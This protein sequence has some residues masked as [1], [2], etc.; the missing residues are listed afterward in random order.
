MLNKLSNTGVP[1]IK[2]ILFNFLIL[3][4]LL[5]LI[6][7]FIPLWSE[8]IVDMISIF[9]FIETCWSILGN[10]LWVLEMDD[11]SAIVGWYVP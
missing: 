3:A 9:K 11:Y 7:R 1:L 8:K 5:L 2:T 4:M 6:S 10:V